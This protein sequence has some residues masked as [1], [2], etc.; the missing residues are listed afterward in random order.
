MVPFGW[1]GLGARL[2][3]RWR[4]VP[5]AV[6]C[7]PGCWD[8]GVADQVGIGSV[9]IVCQAVVRSGVQGQSVGRCSQVLR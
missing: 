8:G 9:L 7:V 2:S 6:Y 3:R 5:R 4:R 1:A